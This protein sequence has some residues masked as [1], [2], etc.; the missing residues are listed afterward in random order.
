MELFRNAWDTAA[1]QGN[2]VMP[3]APTDPELIAL[4]ALVKVLFDTIADSHETEISF[5]GAT[6]RKA[7]NSSRLRQ[8]KHR[9]RRLCERKPPTPFAQFSGSTFG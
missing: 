2:G 8:V 4:R 5:Y 3:I 7:T 1:R 6:L 9:T